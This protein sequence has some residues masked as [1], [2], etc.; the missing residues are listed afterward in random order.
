MFQVVKILMSLEKLLINC[1]V[2]NLFMDIVRGF[3]LSIDYLRLMSSMKSL[4][5]S[6]LCLYLKELNLSL[7]RFRLENL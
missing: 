1:G 2:I 4:L 5:I 3:C 7:I 6:L